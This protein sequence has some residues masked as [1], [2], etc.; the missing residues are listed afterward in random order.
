MTKIY[1]LSVY[2][3]DCYSLSGIG[4]CE[5]LGFSTKELAE[6]YAKAN[7]LNLTEDPSNNNDCYIDII[8]LDSGKG[9]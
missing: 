4:V 6:E 8:E 2:G 9:I 5:Q 7:K 1:M 3:S